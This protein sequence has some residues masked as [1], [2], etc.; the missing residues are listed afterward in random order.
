M[1]SL[2]KISP[3]MDESFLTMSSGRGAAEGIVGA[4]AWHC[5]GVVASSVDGAWSGLSSSSSS[6]SSPSELF[7]GDGELRLQLDRVD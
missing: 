4:S 1:V 7:L 5:V 2:P 6:A 3:S